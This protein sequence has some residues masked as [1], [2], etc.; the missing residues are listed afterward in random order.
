KEA[1]DKTG[2]IYGMG[3]AV[4]SLSDPREVVFKKYVKQLAAEKGRE[5][6]L[7]L[8][9]NVEALTPGLIAAHRRM[10]KGVCPNVDFYS[11][12]VYKMLGIPQELYTAMF[13]VARIVGWSAHRI[14]ELICMDKII[15]PAYMSIMEERQMPDASGSE[16]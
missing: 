8:Y 2:L 7:Q 10:Y 9:E 15:R 1:F 5:K 16:S 11:G 6:E 12:F 4:Y 14:E 13:A 3:H